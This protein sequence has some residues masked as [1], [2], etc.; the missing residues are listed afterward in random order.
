MSVM[1]LS[2]SACSPT[3]DPLHERSH[4]MGGHRRPRAPERS[5]GVPRDFSFGLSWPPPSPT[6]RPWASAPACSSPS[7]LTIAF[8]PRRVVRRSLYKHGLRRWG[9]SKKHTRAC[10]GSRAHRNPP[11]RRDGDRRAFTP[12]GGRVEE[13]PTSRNGRRS[14]ST[15]SACTRDRIAARRVCVQQ[16]GRARMLRPARQQGEL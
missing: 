4:G 9:E 5:E 6:G 1:M 11:R 2:S 10:G 8:Q 3:F 12:R 13:R 14:S 7:R 16:V 15:R